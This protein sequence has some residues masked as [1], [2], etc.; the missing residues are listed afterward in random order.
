M[1]NIIQLLERMGQD[2]NLQTQQQLS[3]EIASS[4]IS[5]ALKQA[6]LEQDTVSLEKQLDVCPD[7]QCLMLPAEDEKP[8]D[9]K[10]SDKK[11]EQDSEQSIRHCA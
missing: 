2:A 11:P 3:S 9:D 4:D 8:K 1:S 5:P 10:E 6:L 7:V